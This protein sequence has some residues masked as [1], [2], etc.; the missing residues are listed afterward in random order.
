MHAVL[1]IELVD[2]FMHKVHSVYIRRPACTQFR[3]RQV[4]LK[5]KIQ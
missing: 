3:V 5:Y 2:L 1:I 4:K